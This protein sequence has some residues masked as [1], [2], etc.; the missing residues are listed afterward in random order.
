MLRL[1]DQNSK[2]IHFANYAAETH[3]SYVYS[4]LLIAVA[5]VDFLVLFLI[6]FPRFLDV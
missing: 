6:L 4:I 1:E 5:T 3:T 2:S